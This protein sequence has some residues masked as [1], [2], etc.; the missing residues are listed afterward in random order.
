MHEVSALNSNADPGQYIGL[1]VLES[2]TSQPDLL[3]GQL[4]AQPS[5]QRPDSEK[6]DYRQ[7][8]RTERVA[9]FI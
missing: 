3:S 1:Q 4:V 7:A 6:H 9:G 5:K 8:G 2:H